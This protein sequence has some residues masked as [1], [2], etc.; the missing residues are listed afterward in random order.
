MSIG[1]AQDTSIADV[2]ATTVGQPRAPITG[3]TR[4][5][6]KHRADAAQLEGLLRE[7][8]K[9]IHCHA[10]NTDKD[11]LR[12]ARDVLRGPGRKAEIASPGRA[13]GATNVAMLEAPIGA[14][15]I[16]ADNELA[17]PR[18][19]ASKLSRE[20]LEIVGPEWLANRRWTGRD[21]ND[22]VVDPAAELSAD[23]LTSLLNAQIRVRFS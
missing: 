17:Y 13:V 2:D 16:W 15:F 18:K 8:V 20:D 5:T 4:T 1:G 6:M 14:V 9:I 21:L 12:R 10:R 3:E 23:E 19:L 11:W 7:A 22:I